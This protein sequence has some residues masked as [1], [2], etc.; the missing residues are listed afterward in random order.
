M[1][2]LAPFV[3]S[4]PFV[5]SEGFADLHERARIPCGHFCLLSVLPLFAR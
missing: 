4:T 5:R 3:R 2:R 1:L